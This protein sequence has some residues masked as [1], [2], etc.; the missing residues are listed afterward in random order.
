MRKK[1]ATAK[2]IAGGKS[3][4]K[5]KA[6]KKKARKTAAKKSRA[7]AAGKNRTWIITTSSDRPIADIGRDLASAGVSRRRVLKDVGSII[8]S[9]KATSIPKLRAIRGVVDVAPDTAINIG[10][11]DSSMTW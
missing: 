7:T 10:P 6:A 2:R 5:R 4:P 3:G 11:P 1:K 8:V 9:A